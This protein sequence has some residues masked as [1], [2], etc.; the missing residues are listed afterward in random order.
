MTQIAH[1]SRELVES[2]DE[3]VWAVNPTN[4]SVASLASY[5]CHFAEEFF[6]AT[7]IRCRLDVAD[8]LPDAPLTAEVRHHLYLAVREAVN[9]LA[10]HSKAAEAWLRIGT[11]D[12]ELRIEV[13]DDGRGFDAAAA[14]PVD[15][16]ANMRRRMEAIGGRFEC[17]AQPG[18]GAVC[19]FILPLIVAAPKPAEGR[20]L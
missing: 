19:R 3:I 20:N 6:N 17:A 4:D 2:L 14:P 13:Q 15:G 10:K 8:A 12:G 18:S 7:P 1:K 9:N 16:L 5:L 11:Q